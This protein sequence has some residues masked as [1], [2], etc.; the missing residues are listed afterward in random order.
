MA[1]PLCRRGVWAF[2][3]S[4][5]IG[6]CQDGGFSI[7]QVVPER[8][9]TGNFDVVAFEFHGCDEPGPSQFV[10]DC[11]LVV[12]VKFG[13]LGSWALAWVGVRVESTAQKHAYC[14]VTTHPSYQT[15]RQIREVVNS[16]S[17]TLVT[18]TSQARKKHDSGKPRWPP[19]IKTRTKYCCHQKG[20]GKTP[21]RNE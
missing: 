4:E 18:A 20:I 21:Q 6:K 15:C 2:Q 8:L 1:C 5:Q 10:T 14:P 17:S 7:Q 3:I 9:I 12:G 19:P 11:D 13:L 16:S